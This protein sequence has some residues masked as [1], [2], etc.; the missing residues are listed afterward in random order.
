MNKLAEMTDKLIRVGI[1]SLIF[2]LPLLFIPNI[3]D[4]YLLPKVIFLR[5]FTLLIFFLFL[6]KSFE[7]KEISF[8]W[9][10]L[11]IPILSLVFISFLTTLFSKHFHT[12]F[13]GVKMRYDG[14]LTFLSYSFLY[15]LVSCFTWKDEQIK[16]IAYGLVISATLISIYT[17]VQFFGYDPFSKGVIL[18]APGRFHGTFESPTFLG[19]FL[20][21]VLPL[22]LIFFKGLRK[23]KPLFFVLF[24]L[25][26]LLI[27]F[28]LVLTQTFSAWLSA[29]IG[30]SFLFFYGLKGW[31]E[32]FYLMVLLSLLI[33]LIFL[34][35]LNFLVKEKIKSV[36]FSLIFS[37]RIKIW[38]VSLKILKAEPLGI[39]QDA[40]GIAFPKYKGERWLKEVAEKWRTTD[41][42]HN[43]F[44]QVG[45]TNGFIGL[46][47]Y[48]WIWVILWRLLPSF[49]KKNSL[50]IAIFTGIL[51]FFIW[52]QFNFTQPSVSPLFWTFIALMMATLGKLKRIKIK[53]SPSFKFPLYLFFILIFLLAAAKGI[54]VILADENLV[55]SYFYIN[56]NL[57]EKAIFQAQQAIKK[58]PSED[59]YY[60]V[61]S[62]SYLRT[63]TKA[64]SGQVYYLSALETLNKAIE[65]NPYEPLNYLGMGEAY[66]FFGLDYEKKALRKAIYWLKKA[67][68]MEPELLEAHFDLIEAYKRGDRKKEALSEVKEILKYDPQNQRALNLL[69]ELRLKD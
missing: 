67:I 65:L 61:L 2:F 34:S 7:Q 29:F 26:F 44:L 56:Q 59:L 6:I 17:V 37:D 53:S 54:K 40:F 35:S 51:S 11:T 20:V 16:K 58:N 49:L 68:K 66:L 1:F 12:S 5:I 25:S 38:E 21:M 10:P 30:F 15:F 18:N 19:V 45:T 41:K 24:S 22:N 47:F 32:R 13:Y 36:L 27:S 46:A 62:A 31:R 55:W 69:R 50:L 9:T 52:L 33:F 28:G 57:P 64:R 8:N 48:L 63:S 23:L 43:D 4:Q 42:A 39:G 3:Y 60:R 14:F